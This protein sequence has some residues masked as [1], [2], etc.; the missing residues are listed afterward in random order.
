MSASIFDLAYE[1]A[2]KHYKESV[3]GVFQDISAE[4]PAVDF[5]LPHRASARAM[6]LHFG[7]L[8]IAEKVWAKSI[9]YEKAQ[10]SLAAQF[11][12]FSIEV[13][14]RALSEAYVWTR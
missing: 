13:S 14:R 9:S 10:E 7:A 12:E 11:P 3:L 5:D 2:I 1:K 6:E 4:N 8:K